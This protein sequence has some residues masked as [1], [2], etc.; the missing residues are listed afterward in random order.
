[1]NGSLEA[2]ATAYRVAHPM[3]F[4]SDLEIASFT[5]DRGSQFGKSHLGRRLGKIKDLPA[6]VST[7]TTRISVQ[8]GAQ[9]LMSQETIAYFQIRDCIPCVSMSRSFFRHS[10]VAIWAAVVQTGSA[11]SAVVPKVCC[12]LQGRSLWR[13]QDRNHSEPESVV[14]VPSSL[15]LSI[16]PGQGELAVS[17]QRKWD[18]LGPRV[19]RELEGLRG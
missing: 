1:M 11:G 5:V 14:V 12:L 9:Q 13:Q 10:V 17:R 8:S 19:K 4:S 2:T 15:D 3:G 7:A 16:Q 6:L 18:T